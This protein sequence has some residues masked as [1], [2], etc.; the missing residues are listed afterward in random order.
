MNKEKIAVIILAGGIG[1][2]F[3]SDLPKQF[4]EISSIPIVIITMKVFDLI[5]EINEIYL[6]LPQE[7]IDFFIDNIL[8]KYSFT[9]TIK[10]VSGGKT[11]QES[12]YNAVMALKDSNPD[13]ILIHDAVRPFVSREI[14]ID[15]IEAAKRIGACDVAVKAIDT[16]IEVEDNLVGSVLKRE[17][18]YYGQTPQA[19]KFNIIYEAHKRAKEDG[20]TNATDDVGLVKR[21][22]QKV[23]V[24]EGDY[25][26]I[27]I[28]N[29]FDFEVARVIYENRK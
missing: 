17:K 20:I 24:V 27:K 4:I 1:E 21:I 29:Q 3:D 2:R 26:N 8:V 13:Y 23:E 28:T 22:G 12:S 11:R 14:I 16:I 5:K 15:S 10:I 9:K 6:V 19:F 25:Q 18:L 7:Y